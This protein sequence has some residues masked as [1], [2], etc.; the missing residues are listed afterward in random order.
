MTS[1]ER[2]LRAIGHEE[3]DRVP[4]QCFLTP[5]METALRTRFGRD[6]LD[7]FDV[8]F[9]TVLPVQLAPDRQPEPGSGIDV[10]D[11]FGVGYVYMPHPAG[12]TYR[13]AAGFE[14]ARLETLDDVA[15]YPWWPNPDDYD[16]GAIPSLIAEQ[17]DRCIV[18]G[19]SGVPDLI[20]G[21]GRGRGMDHLL[22]D[23][24]L[25]D[26]VAL[27]ICDRRVSF[28]LE[29][30]RRTLRAGEGRI[31]ILWIGEDLG[32]QR[33]P[34]VSPSLFDSFFRPRLQ[35]FLDLGH[36]FG[37]RVAMHSCGSTRALMPRLVEMGLDVLDSVQ[38]EPDGMVPAE[39]KAEF[40]A[41]LTFCG[42]ISTQRTLPHGTPEEVRAE[43]RHMV[44]LMGAGG[45]YI[46]AP[47]H[48]IQPDVPVG[49]VL[50]MYSEGL[51]REVG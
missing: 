7:A 19:W 39:L 12:G 4:V 44:E 28:F 29:Y 26:E 3:T 15:S 5:E 18:T 10:Y 27:A 48:N 22:E 38:P 41:D 40:G 6:P 45:G 23:L 37:C 24:L 42:L 46:L 51:G 35:R 31:D 30:L 16:Y 49:N 17:P 11:R 14:L 13:E 21:V 25:E 36:E 8:D 20:N 2:A 47:A 32:T 1:R 43:V 9:R 50:A 34:T 33:G